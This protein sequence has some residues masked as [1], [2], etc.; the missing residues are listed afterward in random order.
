[1][2][3]PYRNVAQENGVQGLPYPWK[4]SALDCGRRYY[5]P[6]YVMLSEHQRKG[7]DT[8]C[9]GMQKLQSKGASITAC[10]NAR[11]GSSSL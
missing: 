11:E 4:S 8:A 7:F 10:V 6:A 3:V 9:A 1:M 5:R 2:V